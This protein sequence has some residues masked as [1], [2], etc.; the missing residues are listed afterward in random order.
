MRK[1]RVSASFLFAILWSVAWAQAAQ[2]TGQLRDS[3][4]LPAHASHHANS[5]TCSQQRSAGPVFYRLKLRTLPLKLVPGQKMSIGT[6]DPRFLPAIQPGATKQETFDQELAKGAPR[7]LGEVDR[8]IR[9]RPLGDGICAAIVS[10]NFSSTAPDEMPKLESVTT[11]T[12]VDKVVPRRTQA[13]DLKANP[14]R[15]LRSSFPKK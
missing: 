12:P 2:T 3:I 5:A 7:N 15:I 11:C 4:E 9:L 14:P 10:Y 1:L 13:P 8:G 6:V